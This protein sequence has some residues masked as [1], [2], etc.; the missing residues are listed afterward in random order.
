MTSIYTLIEQSI[1]REEGMIG[2]SI[3]SCLIM[4]RSIKRVNIDPDSSSENVNP[5]GIS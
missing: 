4:D 5:V 1:L 3:H 2:E